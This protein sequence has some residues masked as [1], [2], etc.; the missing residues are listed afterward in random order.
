MRVIKWLDDLVNYR[1]TVELECACPIDEAVQRLQSVVGSARSS[2]EGLRGVVS[3]NYVCVYWRTPSLRAMRP[4]VAGSFCTERSVT[5]LR[6]RFVSNIVLRILMSIWFAGV[7]TGIALA[8]VLPFFDPDW[9]LGRHL[10][11]IGLLTGMLLAGAWM[12]HRER[13][14][15]R[16][17]VQNIINTLECAIGTEVDSHSRV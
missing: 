16:E 6:G 17:Y 3:H 14:A 10:A 8:L 9:H 13:A 15:C 2:R 4:Y 1:Q 7:L 11:G 12:V 5:V